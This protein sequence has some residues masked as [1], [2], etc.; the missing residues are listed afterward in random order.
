WPGGTEPISYQWQLN[1]QDLPGETGPV[2]WVYNASFADAG[3]Y[4]VVVSNRV[5]SVTSQGATLS[6]GPWIQVFISPQSRTVD[7]GA[8]VTLS[9]NIVGTSPITY[10]RSEER[11][12]GEECRC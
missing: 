11:R 9:A 3:V 8:N 6:V 12:V 2:L 4:T 1:G 7:A 5:V 10:Q